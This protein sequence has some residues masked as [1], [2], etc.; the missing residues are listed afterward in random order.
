MEHNEK[1]KNES[2]D[3]VEQYLTFTLDDEIFALDIGS[4]REVLEFESVTRVPQTPDYMKGVINLRGSVVPVVD[5]KL[6]LGMTRTEKTINT[7]II[8]VEITLEGDHLLLGAIA[9]SVQEVLELSEIEAAPKIGTRLNTEFIDG[10]GKHGDNFIIILN[11]NKIFDSE[12]LGMLN[13]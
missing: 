9:D 2:L 5:L 1:S 12:S 13:G 6:K 7:C 8:I 10:M 3:N 11:I 4:I